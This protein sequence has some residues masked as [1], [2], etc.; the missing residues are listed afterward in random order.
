MLIDKD[1]RHIRTILAK[2]GVEYFTELVEEFK[3]TSQRG[4]SSM[5]FLS[6]AFSSKYFK[7]MDEVI[8]QNAQMNK[9]LEK[10]LSLEVIQLRVD[11][12][13]RVHS[14]DFEAF[15]QR[16]NTIQR[17]FQESLA[18]GICSVGDILIPQYGAQ[19]ATKC[20]NEV[21]KALK[22]PVVKE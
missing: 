3:Q 5:F 9:R 10:Q 14:D 17:V 2:L 21:L 15:L 8:D 22:L 20:L 4:I 16:K 12:H 1:N 18:A 19:R 6:K 11:P 7:I 13:L